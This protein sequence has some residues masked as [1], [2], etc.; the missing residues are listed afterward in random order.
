[1]VSAR[2]A[3]ADV[4]RCG[5]LWQE[6]LA[7]LQLLELW[8]CTLQPACACRGFN[9]GAPSQLQPPAHHTY[10]WMDR[11]MTRHVIHFAGGRLHPELSPSRCSHVSQ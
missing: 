5:G 2:W 4:A 1:M 3:Q 11:A 6:G 10:I 8:R 7:G 9:C